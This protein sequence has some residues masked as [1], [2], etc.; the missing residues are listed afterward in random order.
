MT[1]MEPSG[2][3]PAPTRYECK[4]CDRVERIDPPRLGTT[5]EAA[6]IVG[7]RLGPGESGERP[8]YCPECTGVNEDYWDDR[9]LAVAQMAGIDAGNTAWGG[10]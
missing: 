1:D 5:D 7:W 6:R 3:K 8:E 4:Y 10:A 2:L 9:T